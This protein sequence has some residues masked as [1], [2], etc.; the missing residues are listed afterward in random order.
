MKTSLIW[1]LSTLLSAS[2]WAQRPVR[3]TPKNVLLVILDDYGAISSEAYADIWN[4]SRYAS[5][6]HFDAICRSGVRFERAWSNPT[7]SPTR[8]NILTGR[9]SFRNGVGV[10]CQA[11]VDNIKP[12]EVTIPRLLAERAPEFATANIGK[13]HL[14]HTDDVD[15]LNAPNF[16]GWQHFAGLLANTE[17]IENDYYFLWPRTV[18]GA[19]SIST[20]YSTT[21]YVDDAIAFLNA[22]D[23]GQP[24]FLWQAFFAPHTP[25]HVPPD[26]LHTRIDLDEESS[27]IDKFEAMVQAADTELGRLLSSLPDTDAD[28]LPDETLVIVMGDNGTVDNQGVMPEPYASQELAGKGKLSEHGVRIPLCVAGPGVVGGRS[29]DDLVQATDL[30]ATTFDMLEIDTEGSSKAIDSHSFAHVLRDVD[31]T[32]RTFLFTEQFDQVDP[33]PFLEYGIALRNQRY[34]YV[35]TQNRN[36]GFREECF[37]IE[38]D[39]FEQRGLDLDRCDDLRTVGLELICSEANGPWQRWCD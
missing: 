34:R 33:T 11:G 38:A 10:P 19:E 22:R 8:A 24:F 4:A 23:A 35:R 26:A 18:N 27:N 30:L 6:P 36:R 31:G 39:V 9:H 3:D 7:C 1:T 37:E 32:S 25:F 28:G 29:V 15:G 12:D 21:Q 14:G 5:T 17:E 20:T 13:W 16:M 2:A